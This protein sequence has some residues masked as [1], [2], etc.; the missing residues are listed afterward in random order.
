[1]R[2]RYL[3]PVDLT[4]HGPDGWLVV[5]PDLPEA[6]T[7]GDTR[8]DA[9]V[10]ASDCLEEALAGRMKQRASIPHPGPSRGRPMVAPGALIAGKLALYEAMQAAGFSQ[11]ALAARLGVAEG[12]VRRMLDPRHATRIDRLEAALAKLGRRLVISVEDAA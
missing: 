4:D 9:L 5:L 2:H 7:G 10:Q 6:I 11:V 8:D 1:M 12:E 3:Y